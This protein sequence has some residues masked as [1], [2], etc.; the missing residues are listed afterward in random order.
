M[1]GTRVILGLVG[2][3]YVWGFVGGSTSPIFNTTSQTMNLT[4]RNKRQQNANIHL[5]MTI[6]WEKKRHASRKGRTACRHIAFHTGKKNKQDPEGQPIF[7]S[8]MFRG[9]QCEKPKNLNFG[10]N[11]C[12]WFQLKLRPARDPRGKPPQMAAR[13]ALKTKNACAITRLAT[14]QSAKSWH[15]YAHLVPRRLFDRAPAHASSW[16]HALH[17]ENNQTKPF[18]YLIHHSS[19]RFQIDESCNC[20]GNEETG[21]LC[22]LWRS[23]W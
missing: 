23:Q 2:R 6:V 7:D 16:R 9:Q 12:F 18:D 11:F 13:L 19:C 5:H 22:L 14:Q 20:S 1:T 4:L 21:M 3:N 15:C 10:L 17:Q 8:G